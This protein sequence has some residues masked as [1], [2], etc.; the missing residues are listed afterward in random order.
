MPELAELDGRARAALVSADDAVRIGREELA[1]AAAVA[2]AGAAP[3]FA[4]AL[5]HAEGS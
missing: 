5:H 3:S 1:A 2:G 4:Q